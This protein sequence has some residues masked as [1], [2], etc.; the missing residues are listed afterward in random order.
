MTLI[1]A[2][3]TVDRKRGE[4]KRR[5]RSRN[6]L[7]QLRLLRA[8]QLQGERSPGAGW[9]LNFAPQTRG[10]GFAN[11]PLPPSFPALR[12]TEILDPTDER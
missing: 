4:E 5:D 3:N 2:L 7:C 1:I 8:R 6:Q 11:S 10:N 12:D 9:D